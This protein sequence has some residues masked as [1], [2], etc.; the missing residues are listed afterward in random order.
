ML[1]ANLGAGTYP[2]PAPQPQNQG[3][4]ERL[5]R[6][7]GSQI[8]G[9]LKSVF[10]TCADL[11]DEAAVGENIRLLAWMRRQYGSLRGPFIIES[12]VT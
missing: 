2:S 10:V 7:Q 6:A 9:G 12:I 4:Q 8:G 1:R 11:A 3:Q 5:R